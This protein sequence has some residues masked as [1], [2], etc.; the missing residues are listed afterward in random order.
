MGRHEEE[1]EE[2]EEEAIILVVVV[3]VVVKFA[4]VFVRACVCDE[5]A[6]RQKIYHV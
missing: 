4:S 6:Q 1:E 3:V 5:R 2:E